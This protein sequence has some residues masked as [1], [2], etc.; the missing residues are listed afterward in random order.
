[1]LLLWHPLLHLECIVSRYNNH[2][3]VI[4]LHTIQAIVRPEQLHLV[5]LDLGLQLF[6]QLR[7]QLVDVV[8]VEELARARLHDLLHLHHLAPQLVGLVAERLDLTVLLSD[9]LM[10]LVKLRKVVLV[11][12]F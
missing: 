12:L 8:E 2:L 7:R 10:G 3:S 9:A 4:I 5:Q 6:N 11:L 1:M